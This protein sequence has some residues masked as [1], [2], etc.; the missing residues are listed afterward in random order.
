MIESCD[1]LREVYFSDDSLD[2]NIFVTK[3]VPKNL[4][5]MPKSEEVYNHS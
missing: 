2:D 3:E 5:I 1:E 4:V